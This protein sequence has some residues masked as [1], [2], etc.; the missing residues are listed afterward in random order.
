[1]NEKNYKHKILSE[2]KTGRREAK[3]VNHLQYIKATPIQA[4]TMEDLEK[5]IPEFVM[6]TWLDEVDDLDKNILSRM[7][8]RDV[9][10]H[11]FDGRT[12]P[13]AL[14]TVRLTFTV[15][16]L[17]AT[18][19][20]HLI[21]HR[22]FSFSAQTT[23]S[24]DARNDVFLTNDAIDVRPNLK[25]R[26]RFLC[27]E[28]MDFYTDAVDDGV[29]LYDARCIMPRALEAKYNMS[30]CITDYIRFI[31]TRLGRQ[32][33]PTEDNILAMRLRDEIL[34]LYPFLAS[35]MPIEPIEWHYVKATP[36]NVSLNTYMPSE[37]HE[38]LV[39]DEALSKG[40]HYNN[41]EYYHM[42]RRDE[43]KHQTN[44]HNLMNNRK[45]K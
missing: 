4:M 16:G 9:V 24:R 40:E 30:G 44:F 35:K 23:D 21:R 26:F 22:N 41:Y 17:S 15:E 29:S 7:S 42:W 27:Q 19:V 28:L 1:M 34:N 25:E 33:Q 8:R 10:K 32:N 11:M 20:T 39:R 37:K 14:E 18:G 2:R 31:N 5:F 13:T 45:H 36:F 6:M 3:F 38:N 43:E 12:L